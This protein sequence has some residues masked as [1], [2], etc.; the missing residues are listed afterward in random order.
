MNAVNNDAPRSHLKE[1]FIQMERDPREGELTADEYVDALEIPSEE[2]QMQGE[3]FRR[4]SEGSL[5][6]DPVQNIK[7]FAKTADNL[8]GENRI[9]DIGIDLADG[10]DAIEQVT[11]DDMLRLV[12]QARFARSLGFGIHG[13]PRIED[14]VM[15][16]RVTGPGSPSGLPIPDAV[17]PFQ[18]TYGKS[19]RGLACKTPAQD[20]LGSE[21]PIGTTRILRAGKFIEMNKEGKFDVPKLE[22]A[23]DKILALEPGHR[24]DLRPDVID[25]GGADYY[26]KVAEA[27]GYHVGELEQSEISGDY[28][29]LPLGA[30]RPGFKGGLE[31]ANSPNQAE[32]TAGKA[33]QVEWGNIGPRRTIELP[34]LEKYMQGEPLTDSERNAFVTRAN[35]EST[36][37]GMQNRVALESVDPISGETKHYEGAEYPHVFTFGG[38]IRGRYEVSHEDTPEIQRTAQESLVGPGGESTHVIIETDDGETFIVQRTSSDDIKSASKQT[39]RLTS[40]AKRDSETGRPTLREVTS[41]QLR[42]VVI[43]PGSPMVL[44]SDAEGRSLRTRGNVVRVTTMQ[45]NEAGQLPPTHPILKKPERRRNTVQ[46]IN[47]A[48]KAI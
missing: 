37:D 12:Q 29:G 14:G 18:G 32:A 8:Q 19:D 13:S 15:K 46:R 26:Q 5:T 39:F 2:D 41:Q 40:T 28:F 27:L 4:A 35:M 36:Y 17:M 24:L 47:D 10:A 21:I 25:L 1:I 23:I 16:L 30:R 20:K 45:K 7:A 3:I 44:N 38:S 48:L 31:I 43:M 6:F 34:Y 9:G 22:Y 42:D 11:H 33:A